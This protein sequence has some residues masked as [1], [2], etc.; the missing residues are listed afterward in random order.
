MRRT[1]AVFLF[2]GML[3]AGCG[4]QG[5]EPVTG[6]EGMVG[7]WIL[8]IEDASTFFEFK[9]DETFVVSLRVD[10]YGEPDPTIRGTYWFE[11]SQLYMEASEAIL[12]PQDE[13]CTDI[14]VYEVQSLKSGN[15]KFTLIDEPCSH[16]EDFLVGPGSEDYEY[17]RME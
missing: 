4:S 15:L 16:R 10:F 13:L 5:R 1:C 12:F 7:L 17:R 6:T 2:L 9:E 3:V 14:G 8:D 11:E